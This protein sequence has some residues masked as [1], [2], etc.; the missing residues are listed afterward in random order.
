MKNE[1]S[2]DLLEDSMKYTTAKYGNLKRIIKAFNTIEDEE[3]KKELIKVWS[4]QKHNEIEKIFIED[5]NFQLENIETSIVTFFTV[6]HILLMAK[7]KR[8]NKIFDTYFDGTRIKYY[9]FNLNTLVK[10]PDFNEWVKCYWNKERFLEELKIV[11][12]LRDFF[13]EVDKS[14]N[15]DNELTLFLQELIQ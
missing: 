14:S 13:Y 15:K 4:I 10:M 7:Y 9:A 3:L 2:K 6:V 11:A 1:I 5:L 8:D 12:V